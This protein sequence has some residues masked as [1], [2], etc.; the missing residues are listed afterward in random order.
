MF[1]VVERN[2]LAAF[3]TYFRG[4]KVG[5]AYKHPA[6]GGLFKMAANWLQNRSI[7]TMSCSIQ[8]YF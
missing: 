7:T 8:S 6:L 1:G 5:F 2:I 3:E 4:L